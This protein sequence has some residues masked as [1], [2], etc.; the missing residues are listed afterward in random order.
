MKRKRDQ[1]R[2]QVGEQTIKQ[3][4]KETLSIRHITIGIDMSLNCPGWVILHPE[5][6]TIEFYWIRQRVKEHS[7]LPILLTDVPFFNQWTMSGTCLDPI[8]K[9]EH[10][11]QIPI[12]N[13]FLGVM[14]LILSTIIPFEPQDVKIAIEGYAYCARQQSSQKLLT[15]LGGCLRMALSIYGY[16]FVEIAPTSAKKHLSNK[17]DM[18]H[19]WITRWRMPS[20]CALIGLEMSKNGSPPHPIEDLIDGFAVSISMMND[21]LVESA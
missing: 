18:Y 6:K 19:A 1:V 12:Y 14:H 13:R 15:E 5:N 20:L 16:N 3:K 11:G 4:R 9:V 2:A 21:P 10:L 7:F 8:E 17:T